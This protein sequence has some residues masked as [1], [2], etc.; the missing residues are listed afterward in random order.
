MLLSRESLVN[1]SLNFFLRPFTERV[2]D[3]RT[4]PLR[5][6]PLGMFFYN[7][8]ALFF[9]FSGMFLLLLLA[10]LQLARSTSPAQTLTWRV[11]ASG[12]GLSI[13][14]TLALHK[15]FADN[16]ARWRETERTSSFPRLF[17]PYLILDSLFIIFLIIISGRL[18]LDLHYY[19]LLL[20][21][22]LVVYCACVAT[23]K[24]A[25]PAQLQVT[26]FVW[27]LCMVSLVHSDLHATN[28]YVVN[29]DQ[30]SLF[31]R[32]VD[33]G[34]QFGMTFVTIMAVLMISWLR[35]CEHRVTQQ[36]LDFLGE[37]EDLLSGPS[38]MESEAREDQALIERESQ[39]RLKSLLKAV[40]SLGSPFWYR[41]GC[42][43]FIEKHQDRGNVLI[44]GPRHRMGETLSEIALSQPLGAP[45]RILSGM[46][47]PTGEPA[48][49][50][51]R[52]SS[53]TEIIALIPVVTKTRECGVLTLHGE[54][55]P[56]GESAAESAFLKTL[57]RIVADMMDQ[58]DSR[59]RIGAQEEIDELFKCESLADIFERAAR[60]FRRY[61]SASCCAIIFRP[62]PTDTEMRVMAARGFKLDMK[63]RLFPCDSDPFR[64]SAA[65]G[66]T[67]RCDGFEAH[68][69]EYPGPAFA[70]LEELHGSPFASW[71]L[72]P[73]G[74]S[75][76]NFGVVL[77]AN[78]RLK[79]HWFTDDDQLLAE[80][81]ALRLQ[82]L[83][84][85]FLYITRTEEA[86]RLA[87]ENA[88]AADAARKVAE[89]AAMQRQDDLMVMTHQLQ[90][91]LYSVK[92]GLELLTTDNRA[93]FMH[94]RLTHIEA[95][96]EDSLALCYGTVTTFAQAAGKK[97]SFNAIQID[98]PQELECL[99][100]R[101][102][103]TNY[104][105]DLKLEFKSDPGFPKLKMDRNVFTGVL[106]S[107]LQ[108]AMKYA[109]KGSRVTLECS[110]ER[111]SGEAALKVKSLGEEIRPEESETIFERYKRGAVIARTGRYHAGVGLGLWVARQLMVAIGGNLTLELNPD[112][113][114]LSVFVVHCP[115]KAIHKEEAAQAAV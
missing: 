68:R 31:H 109:E 29:Q 44:P 9:L 43:W 78:R 83:V 39:A 64:A 8:R 81:L 91:P 17:Y 61:L 26:I 112:F 47:A 62:R 70:L 28:P 2:F 98:A 82:A 19:S 73:I 45:P 25:V 42:F 33:L 5:Q 51:V 107:L 58:W 18:R 85:K 13:L 53:P 92:F 115:L 20:F 48:E 105:G 86:H 74:P 113:P 102:Q 63:G 37:A 59:G 84:D 79:G 52:P 54:G 56:L 90:A 101:L 100:R 114:R 15:Q 16:L 75:N 103:R 110:F 7:Q 24:E 76:R 93:R 12:W 6:S 57:G 1:R 80:R 66:R 94:D 50:F 88:E 104:R 3:D 27:L 69:A 11:L 4:G 60:V 77:V 95:L 23:W 10:P 87:N 96:I 41:S 35:K 40:C 22:N 71:M 30:D 67:Y 106:Y 34:P 65:T 72:I 32:L 55:S 21:A 111:S 97:A 108:N 89:I 14:V 38:A 49:S 36:Q 46:S 99:C